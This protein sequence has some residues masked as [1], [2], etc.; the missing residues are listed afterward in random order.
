M[1]FQAISDEVFP[2]SYAQTVDGRIKCK[3]MFRHLAAS[4]SMPDSTIA[5]YFSKRVNTL[6]HKF[7]THVEVLEIVSQLLQINPDHRLDLNEAL[8]KVEE[9]LSRRGVY[10]LFNSHIHDMGFESTSDD[11][12]HSSDFE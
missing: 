3:K 5:T 2:I 12:L 10:R 11:L 8:L 1:V 7:H 4:I 9:C 6:K